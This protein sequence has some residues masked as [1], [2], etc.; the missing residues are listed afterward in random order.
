MRVPLRAWIYD[1]MRVPLR[2]VSRERMSQASSSQEHYLEYA[3]IREKRS[4]SSKDPYAW[5][6]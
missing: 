3:W 1:R 5:I 2:A 4:T 6:R